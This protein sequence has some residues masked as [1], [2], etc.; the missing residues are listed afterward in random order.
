MITITY[1]R[2]FFLTGC[3]STGKLRTVHSRYERQRKRRPRFFLRPRGPRVDWQVVHFR[4]PL[5]F[6]SRVLLR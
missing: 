6:D 4:D 5:D 3:V 1:P 2:P